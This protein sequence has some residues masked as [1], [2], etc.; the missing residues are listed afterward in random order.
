MHMLK[1]CSGIIMRATCTSCFICLGFIFS[2]CLQSVNL[3]STAYYQASTRHH[4]LADSKTM[5][6]DDEWRSLIEEFE[7]VIAANPQGEWADDSQ[8]AISSCWIWLSQDGNLEAIQHAVGSLKQMLGTYPHSPLLAESHYWLAHC[9]VRRDDAPLAIAHYQEV[10]ID[11]YDSAAAKRAQLALAHIYEKQNHP[12]AAVALYQAIVNRNPDSRLAVEAVE[13]LDVLQAAELSRVVKHNT[14]T[15]KSV[16]FPDGEVPGVVMPETVG[17]VTSDVDAGTTRTKVKN[18]EHTVSLSNQQTLVAGV[19]KFDGVLPAED[20]A[21]RR[22]TTDENNTTQQDS[23]EAHIWNVIA[24]PSNSE[25]SPRPDLSLSRQLGLG[26]K[27]IIIDP[28]HG[29]KDP[30]SISNSWIQEKMIVLELSSMLRDLLVERGYQVRLTRDTDIYLPLQ[31]RTEFS[32]MQ[33]ADLFVSLHAN[34]SPN[35]EASGIETYYLALASDESAQTTAARENVDTGYGIKELDGLMAQIL[36]ESKSVESRRLAQIVQKELILTTKA[37][38]RGVKHAPFVV[39]IGTKVPAILVEVGFLSHSGEAEQ[40]TNA[41]Y[42][43]TIAQAIA[44]GI[45]RYVSSIPV[46]TAKADRY[47]GE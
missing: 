12:S 45:E 5:V 2:S 18:V 1:G 6:S 38:N 24:R 37:K 46:T 39:L 33:G 26:V 22:P 3:V 7:R 25:L 35:L 42:Q 29:G 14:P 36:K 16:S 41:V 28:G 11:Y 13:R 34:A 23:S 30:G 31:D 32:E 40:L 8:F 47:V 10:I 17:I 19:V 15:P 27:T 44:N 20:N 21:A 9:Y 4:E 43:R